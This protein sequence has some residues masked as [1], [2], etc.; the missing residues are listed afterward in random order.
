[1]KRKK[2]WKEKIKGMNFGRLGKQL[3]E[4]VVLGED[5]EDNQERDGTIVLNRYMHGL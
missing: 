4:G 1:M 3:Y 2:S 5:Q